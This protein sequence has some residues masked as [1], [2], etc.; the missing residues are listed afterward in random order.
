MKNFKYGVTAAGVG[1]ACVIGIGIA[2]PSLA[3]N[4]PVLNSIIQGLNDKYGTTSEYSDY[5][6]VIGES[7]TSN[8]VTFTINEV[9]ADE[10][11]LII[12]YTIKSDQKLN[13]KAYSNALSSLKINGKTWGGTG[14]ALGEA[15]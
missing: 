5:S 6:K 2:N 1:I 15:E 14:S 9:L 3:E 13:D 10:A 7:I 12:S 11:K 4:V 8:G